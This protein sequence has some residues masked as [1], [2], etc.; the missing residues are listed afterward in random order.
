[1]LEKAMVEQAYI[2]SG[3]YGDTGSGKTKTSL[4]IA[5]RI[6]DMYSGKIAMIG[7]ERG[8]DFYG[9]EFDFDI[10][11]VS[12]LHEA[13][14]ALD[15]ILGKGYICVIVDQMTS[16]WEWSQ[17]EYMSEEHEKM[18]KAWST[19][20]KS[21]NIPFSGWKKVK[22]PYKKF[23]KKLLDAPIHL[24]LLGRLAYEYEVSD[25]GEKIKKVGE[26]MN[27]EKETPYEPHILVKMEFQKKKGGIHYALVEKDH[28]GTIQGQ[29]FTNPEGDMFDPILKKLGKIQ[30]TLPE[31]I[32]DTSTTTIAQEPIRPSQIKIIKSI[33]KKGGVEIKQVEKFLENLKAEKAGEIINQLT[34]GN[35]SCLQ[36]EGE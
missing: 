32:E 23:L 28:S 1:M 36:Q 13:D 35:F 26:K 31:P 17:N 25:G 34:L 15:E 3:F 29:V 33:C 19:I 5:T 16:I 21:G 2:K 20:E 14:M 9:A 10:A 7:T 6:A 24:F 18:S 8:M 30:G 12:S 4:M 11:R 27:A 22:R